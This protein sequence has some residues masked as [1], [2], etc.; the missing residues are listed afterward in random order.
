M[1]RVRIDF[2]TTNSVIFLY[3]LL[4]D[5]EHISAEHTCTWERYN[6]AHSNIENIKTYGIKYMA[7]L[8]F[9]PFERSEA[10]HNIYI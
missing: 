2:K 6:V 1:G 3:C 9:H 5:N 4:L 8:P 10:S 7:I